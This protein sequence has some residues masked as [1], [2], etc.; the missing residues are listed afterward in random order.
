[1]SI[2][3]SYQSANPRLEEILKSI[4]RPGEFCTY[5]RVAKPIPRLEV[6]K[7]GVLS[8]PVPETQ[9]EKLIKT[10]DQAPY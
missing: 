7:I 3:I 1:M 4:N 5:G 10:A 6:E 2:E 8:I 9:I